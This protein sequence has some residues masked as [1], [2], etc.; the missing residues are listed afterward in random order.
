MAAR[1]G[2]LFLLLL[3][4]GCNREAA[5]PAPLTPEA[6]AYVR[7][8]ALS[9]VEMKAKEA[10][11]GQ[12][13]VEITGNITNNGEQ[14]VRVVEVMCVFYDTNTQAIARERLP[15]VRSSGKSLKSTDT[16]PF[17]LAFDNLPEGW[18]QAMPQLV[19]ANIIFDQ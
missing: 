9:D 2:L 15:I 12:Q 4:L 5:G 18:N 1:F 7:N 14:A 6:K 19:I 11:S 3:C 16:R 8:L 10:Y 17:R 13:V